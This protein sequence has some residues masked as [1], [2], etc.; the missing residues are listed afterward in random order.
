MLVV[1]LLFYFYLLKRIIIVVKFDF[2]KV[3]IDFV[4]YL[5]FFNY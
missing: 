5:I 2:D 3:D 4:D 1:F